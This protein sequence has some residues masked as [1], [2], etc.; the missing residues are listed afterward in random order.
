VERK[1]SAKKSPDFI[2]SILVKSGATA[3]SFCAST[4]DGCKGGRPH[5]SEDQ[6]QRDRNDHIATTHTK[7][8]CGVECSFSVPFFRRAEKKKKGGND[9][10]KPFRPAADRY[11]LVRQQSYAPIVLKIIA[12]MKSEQMVASLFISRRQPEREE[13]G[14]E[15]VGISDESTEVGVPAT[16]EDI[17]DTVVIWRG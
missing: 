4:G 2:S 3:F 13:G 17:G 11:P 8:V 16:W 9:G 14:G 7:R 6:T 1:A 5:I 15:D 10:D 12:L